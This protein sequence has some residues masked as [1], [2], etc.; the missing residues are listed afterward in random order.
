[1]EFETL[2]QENKSLKESLSRSR[3]SILNL[4]EENQKLSALYKSTK[5]SFDKILSEMNDSDFD[6][7]KSLTETIQKKDEYISD[8]IKKYNLLVEEYN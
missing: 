8:L 6:K 5:E 7:Y 3:N 1:K 4:T 2:A